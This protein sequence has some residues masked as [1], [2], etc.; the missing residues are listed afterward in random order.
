[1]SNIKYFIIIK[2]WLNL[3]KVTKKLKFKTWMIKNDIFLAV[4]L[5][6]VEQVR[7]TI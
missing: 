2:S 5:F 7:S 4:F 6:H 3:K 1:M